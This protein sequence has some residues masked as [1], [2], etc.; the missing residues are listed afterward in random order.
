MDILSRKHKRS[1]GGGSDDDSDDGPP[2]D[3]D[4]VVPAPVK[5]EKDKKTSGDVKEV[6]VSVRKAGDEKSG[7]HLQG[8]V[9]AVRREMLMIIRGEEDEKWEDYEYCDHRVGSM[10]YY[11][12]PEFSH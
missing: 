3:P 5:K 4:E 12:K 9:T 10:I 7:A 1:R 6:Q 11:H 2:P 8:G